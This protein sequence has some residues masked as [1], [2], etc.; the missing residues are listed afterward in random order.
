MS[1]FELIMLLCFGVAWPFS[2]RKSIISKSVKGKSFAFL[3]IVWMGYLA[4]IL[5]KIFYHYDIVIIFY[6]INFVMVCIDM[7]LYLKNKKTVM[8]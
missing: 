8:K 4:G 6:I 5:H 7:L 1:V 2:I 3:F